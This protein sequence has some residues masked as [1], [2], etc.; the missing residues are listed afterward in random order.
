M[1]PTAD[2][3]ALITEIIRL[4]SVHTAQI[5][6]ILRTRLL[7]AALVSGKQGFTELGPGLAVDLV[8]GSD[9]GD[10]VG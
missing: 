3:G 8:Q 5:V 1:S 2:T 4:Y 9:L 7:V 10:H 6:Q